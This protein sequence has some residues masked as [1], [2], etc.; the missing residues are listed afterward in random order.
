MQPVEQNLFIYL[1]DVVLFLKG[2]SGHFLSTMCNNTS[3]SNYIIIC[4]V[5]KHK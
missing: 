2:T 4:T 1:Y 5:Q 3:H